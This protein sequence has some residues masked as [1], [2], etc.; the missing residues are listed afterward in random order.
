MRTDYA[1]REFLRSRKLRDVSDRT[2]EAY[3]WALSKLTAVYPDKLPT[4]AE[5]MHE[6]FTAFPDLSPE[7]RKSLWRRLGTFCRWLEREGYS[8]N[9]M[10]NIPAPLC[11]RKLPRTLSESETQHLLASIDDERDYAIMVVLLDTGIRVGE[12]ASVTRDALSP[13]GIRVSGKTGDRIVPISPGVFDLVSRQGDEGGI[14]KSRGGHRGYLGTWGLKEI[15][16]RQ[17]LGAGFRPPKIGPHTLRHTF[18][19]QYMLNGGDVF[20]LRRI[21][22]HSRIETT[23]LYAEMSDTLVAQQHRKFSPMA[24][25]IKSENTE[26]SY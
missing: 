16:R 4:K 18:G 6:V 21:M 1:A 23:M 22:G 14:W 26:I 17:M 10:A 8:P 15:V 20:S 5:E 7:S 25:L 13:N 12:L 2:I 3:T 19:T 24:R 11:R 9:L